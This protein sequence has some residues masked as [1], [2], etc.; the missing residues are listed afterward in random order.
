MMYNFTPATVDIIKMSKNNKCWRG[1]RE[2][3]NLLHCGWKCKLIEPLWEAI[4]RFLKKLKTEVPYDPATPL[5]G[6]CL[7]KT[8]NQ[9]YTCTSVSVVATFTIA[10]MWKQ[11]KCLLM[12]EQMRCAADF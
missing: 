2:K 10:R 12:E 5:L 9:K 1:C 6:M 8:I 11:P 7:E 4:W 3:R